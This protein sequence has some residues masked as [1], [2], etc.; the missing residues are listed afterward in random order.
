MV[1]TT[2]TSTRFLIALVAALTLSLCA[3]RVMAAIG[4]P[5]AATACRAAVPGQK[6]LALRE[7]TRNGVWVYEGDLVE[8]PPTRVTTATIERDTGAL[9]DVASIVIPSDEL[10]AIQQS[11][12]RLNYATVDFAQAESV[13]SVASLRTD[14]ERIE[15]LY[16]GGILAYRV[17]YFDDPVLI[18]VDSITG[19]VIPSPLP[20]LA[21]EPTVRV[22]EMAGA[23]AHAQWYTSAQWTP[24]EATA[25]QRIDGVTVRVLFVNRVS[26]FM[27]R[28]EVVQGFLIPGSSFVPV[29]QQ[30]AR[31]AMVAI[32]SPVICPSISAL[33][34]VQT[35]SPG[36]GVNSLSLEL[37]GTAGAY[38]YDWVTRFVDASETE[39]DAHTDATQP[40][41]KKGAP[42]FTAPI[43]LA[44]VDFTRDGVVDARDLTELL[45]YWG[46]FNALL[47]V[48][49]TGFVDAGDLAMLL[50]EWTG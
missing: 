37:G 50:S 24:I 32:G 19:G 26:G 1:R 8:V 35:A 45:A 5:A 39:R 21:I 4:F 11:V 31:A 28:H 33:A 34:A 29:G 15:L 49:N 43:D 9:L 12:Q 38:T 40:V 17:S 46:A 6:L 20:G 7:R 2:S 42:Q 48:N 47:D 16:E 36:L 10:P 22:A 13:A 44:A 3:D 30:I 25:T 18:E 23:I 41:S 14:T 27:V